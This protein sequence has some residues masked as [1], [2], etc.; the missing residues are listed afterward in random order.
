M[1][2][3]RKLTIHELDNDRENISLADDNE[4]TTVVHVSVTV[5]ISSN[6]LYTP[7]V[8]FRILLQ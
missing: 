4:N 7:F 5:L 6:V 8:S 2:D 1:C 3:Q